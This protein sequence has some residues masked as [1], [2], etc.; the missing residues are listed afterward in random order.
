MKPIHGEP[1]PLWQKFGLN[2][3]SPIECAFKI[4]DQVIY[5]ND[6]GLK[7]DMEVIGFSNNDSFQGRFI[8][9]VRAGHTGDGNAWWFPHHPQELI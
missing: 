6:A 1:K 2:E 3:F 9:L 4:G 5:T 7:F 8:H